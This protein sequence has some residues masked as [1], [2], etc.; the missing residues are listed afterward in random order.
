M[1]ANE[2]LLV[3][4][5]ILP[6]NYLFTNYIFNV[7]RYK[8]DLPLNN[9]QELICNKNINQPTKVVIPVQV[10]SIYHIDLFKND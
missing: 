10:S 5:I 8:K 4:K 2:L 1:Q 9:L 6:W 7:Y 3:W